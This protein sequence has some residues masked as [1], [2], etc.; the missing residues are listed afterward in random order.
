MGPLQVFVPHHD[1]TIFWGPLL[2]HMKKQGWSQ[3]KRKGDQGEARKWSTVDF[4][5]IGLFF[6]PV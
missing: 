5:G 1:L 3:D 4:L 6:S 2:T